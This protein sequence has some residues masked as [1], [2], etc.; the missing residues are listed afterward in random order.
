MGTPLPLLVRPRKFEV[1]YK[2]K[3]EDKCRATIT[4]H[5]LN[6]MKFTGTE[7]LVSE[8]LAQISA[9]EVYRHDK[10]RTNR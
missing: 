2:E 6:E 8:R 4:L 5:V 10:D 3:L 9:M 7:W 1:G